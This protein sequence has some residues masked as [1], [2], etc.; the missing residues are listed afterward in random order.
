MH[1]IVHAADIQD[2][3]G[4]AALMAATVFGAFPFLTGF[5]PRRLPLPAR[6]LTN[7]GA[8]EGRDRQVVGP[9]QGPRRPAEAL[10]RRTAPSPAGSP[11]AANWPRIGNASP[12][13][14]SLRLA[15][16]RLML[17]KTMQSHVMFRTDA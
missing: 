11:A 10:A 3:D 17:Q 4:G 13:R 1:A 9:G 16:L 14:R 6:R 7:S 8:G 2:R 5:V 15:S 12:A